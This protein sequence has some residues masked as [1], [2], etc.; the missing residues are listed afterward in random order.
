[1]STRPHAEP[2]SIWTQPEPGARKPRLSRARIARA[3]LR[4]AD[5]EG[6][7]AASMRRVASALGAGTMTLYHYVRTREDLLALM[8]DAL[9]GET[10]VRRL[11]THWRDALA[12]IAR[13]TR[14]VFVRHPWV[15]GSMS[16]AAMGP[17]AV[18]HVEQSLAALATTSLDGAAKIEVL[19]LVD[20]FVFGH[21]LRASNGA[22]EGAAE[23]ARS[24]RAA[25]PHIDA[26]AR[27]VQAWKKVHGARRSGE[28]FERGLD[29]LLAGI[30]DRFVDRTRRGRSR[31][32]NVSPRARPT[33]RRRT[34]A[35]R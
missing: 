26:L 25:G 4:L 33:P 2:A 17:N 12:A 34:R 6:L 9:M 5:A 32:K 14:A 11:P 24:P 28:A 19:S 16:H 21:A 29:A 1:M 15:M 31:G 10:L 23:L 8:E 3:A 27:D 20:D 22:H 30:A 13:K 35:P 18:R 7:E